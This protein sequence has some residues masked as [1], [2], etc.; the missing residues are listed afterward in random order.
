MILWDESNL[1]P[2]P[3]AHRFAASGLT[4][5]ASQNDGYQVGNDEMNGHCLSSQVLLPTIYS[6]QRSAK[7]TRL[8]FELFSDVHAAHPY[9]MVYLLQDDETYHAGSFNPFMELAVEKDNSLVLTIYETE[10]TWS[11]TVEQWEEISRRARAYHAEV[12]A[13]GEDW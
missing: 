7:M 9:I 3:M 4:F 6:I 12:L 13:S 1:K 10:R 8:V 5:S 11:L 2:A